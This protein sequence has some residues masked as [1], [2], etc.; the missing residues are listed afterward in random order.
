MSFENEK[1]LSKSEIELL[2]SEK[3]L[4]KLKLEISKDK[5]QKNKILNHYTK[6]IDR[7]KSVESKEYITTLF[8]NAVIF[9][10]IFN[11][12]EVNKKN[13]YEKSSNFI[14]NKPEVEK[15]EEV[16]WETNKKNVIWTNIKSQ[17][18]KQETEIQDNILDN[19]IFNFAKGLWIEISNDLEIKKD[20]DLKTM[21]VNF[22]NKANEFLKSYKQT[23]SAF[24]N[25]SIDEIRNEMRSGFLN[26]WNKQVNGMMDKE[27]ERYPYLSLDKKNE[28]RNDIS[29]DDIEQKIGKIMP[30]VKLYKLW[31]FDSLSKTIWNQTES[32]LK[33]IWS[34]IPVIT[35]NN[36]NDE[37]IKNKVLEIFGNLILIIKN[38]I[39]AICKDYL[40]NKI[41]KNDNDMIAFVQE[42]NT[43]WSWGESI[44]TLLNTTNPEEKTKI[45]KLIV[46]LC[47]M[48]QTYF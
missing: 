41:P 27:L 44:E 40:E 1:I 30:M 17:T 21:F 24:D 35:K 28:I 32:Y 31:F 29:K 11:I 4:S 9:L 26:I 6:Y 33:S 18:T 20:I 48:I 16:T 10:W 19:P 39:N 14:N 22:W 3:E 45:Y 36:I 8:L 42:I 34:E 47:D 7:S 25:K 37:N 13:L 46:G 12:T 15:K 2:K 23:F 43:W 38:S 5:N